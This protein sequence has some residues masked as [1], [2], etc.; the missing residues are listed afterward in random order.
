MRSDC[1]SDGLSCIFLL[2]R[3]GGSGDGGIAEPTG[4]ESVATKREI[5]DKTITAAI[6][7]LVFRRFLRE[8][9]KRVVPKRGPGCFSTP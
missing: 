7:C 3:N 5:N 8:L 2:G 1:G 6:I 4:S 9:E